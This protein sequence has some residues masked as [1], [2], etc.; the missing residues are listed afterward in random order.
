ME[1][2]KEMAVNHC[3]WVADH[4]THVPTTQSVSTADSKGT[5]NT[6]TRIYVQIIISGNSVEMHN[7]IDV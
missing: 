2:K 7:N 6:F 1:R 3:S 5:R 4:L